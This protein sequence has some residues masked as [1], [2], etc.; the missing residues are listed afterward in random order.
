VG[1]F[2]YISAEETPHMHD[3]ETDGDM[4]CLIYVAGK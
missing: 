3:L 2:V 1:M 4:S